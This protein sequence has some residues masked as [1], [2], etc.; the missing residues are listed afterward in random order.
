MDLMSAIPGQ[1]LAGWE[2]TLRKTA[3]LRPEHISAYSLIIE[4]GTWF[5]EK[6]GEGRHAEELPG[7]E[8]ERQMDLSVERQ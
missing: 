3:E 5:Y 8:E 7:E 1:R 2:E 6:Y 4:E